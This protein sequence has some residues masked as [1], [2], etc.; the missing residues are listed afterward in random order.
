[1]LVLSLRDDGENPGV[2]RQSVMTEPFLCEQEFPKVISLNPFR[3][4]LIISLF[5]M[6][7]AR[8]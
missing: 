7:K 5:S 8:K 6:L 2:V 3:N 4:T 1:M